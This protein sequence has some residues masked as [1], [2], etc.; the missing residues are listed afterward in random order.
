M[1]CYNGCPD[2]QL[3]AHIDEQNRL[4]KELSLRGATATYF[5]VE[6]RWMIFKDYKPV[7]EFHTT[8]AGAVDAY[9]KVA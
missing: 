6:E 8:L 7:T 2:S 3:Q 5:P 9:K 1:R 4:H